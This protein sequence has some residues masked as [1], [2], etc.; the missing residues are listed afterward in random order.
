MWIYVLTSQQNDDNGLTK[1][2]ILFATQS[3]YLAQQWRDRSNPLK[4]C[5]RDY[6]EIQLGPLPDDIYDVIQ[7][8]D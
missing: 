7:N 3:L 6:V 2:D 8:G 4:N 1:D 5:I